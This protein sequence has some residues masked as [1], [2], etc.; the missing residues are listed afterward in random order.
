MESAAGGLLGAQH[1]AM[2]DLAPVAQH[3]CL[4]NAFPD[5]NI[6]HLFLAAGC[7]GITEKGGTPT[8]DF[9]TGDAQCFTRF[10]SLGFG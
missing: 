5:G 9:Y 7:S 6:R 3:Q 8:S 1:R 10:A 4:M 2:S